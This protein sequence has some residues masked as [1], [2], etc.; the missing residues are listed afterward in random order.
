MACL[1]ST[2]PWPRGP[3]RVAGLQAVARSVGG[4]HLRR[5]LRAAGDHQKS[6]GARARQGVLKEIEVQSNPTVFLPALR[7][8]RRSTVPGRQDGLLHRVQDL[9]VLQRR[10]RG[11]EEG[12]RTIHGSGPR[13]RDQ[14]GRGCAKGPAELGVEDGIER[15]NRAG[16]LSETLHP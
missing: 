12:A 10:L 15:Q 2:A 5:V 11:S 7:R 4:R 13:H 14:L 3:V 1:P 16:R 9:H 6:I 8:R